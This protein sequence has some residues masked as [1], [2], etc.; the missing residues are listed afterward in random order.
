MAMSVLLSLVLLLLAVAPSALAQFIGQPPARFLRKKYVTVHGRR[1]AYVEVGQG[2]PIVFLHGNPSSSYLWRNVMPHL[3]GRGRL[4]APDLIGMGDSAKLPPPDP[5]RYSILHH[6]NF[7]YGL[8]EKL[9]IRR[10]VTL[11]IH[12]WGSAL[13]FN[14][15]YLKRNDPQAVKGIAFLEALVQPLTTRTRPDVIQFKNLFKGERGLQAVLQQNIFIEVLMPNGIMRNL[16][17]KEMNEWRRPFRRPG[18]GRLTMHTMPNE[19]PVDGRPRSTYRMISRYSKWLASSKKVKKL[20]IRGVPGSLIGTP[21]AKFVRSW[22][23]VKEVMAKGI[24]YLQEDDPHTI[25]KAIAKW[26][27]D[28]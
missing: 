17:M 9:D 21:E 23:N 12:D 10:N 28:L 24:H 20:F 11:V 13:G 14:W 22:P 15:A 25:G 7:L 6:S 3:E 4:I 5:T 27:A 18:Q 1:M 8:F 2:D 16:T 26:H 19:I